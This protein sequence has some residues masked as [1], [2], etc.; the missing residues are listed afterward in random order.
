[1]FRKIVSQL[2]FSPA[3]VG[4][5]SFYAKR[6]RR[7]EVT[8]K[9]GLVFVALAL[10]VQSLVVFQ[11]VESANA[12][13]DSDFVR[14]GI[15]SIDE[16]L[17][18]YDSNSNNIKDIMTYA[19]VTRQE[20]ASTQYT[21]FKVNSTLSWG[22]Q[23]RFSAAQGERTVNITNADGNHVRNV[24]ARPLT[25]WNQSNWNIRAWVGHS[26]KLGWFAIMKV[27]GNLVTNSI[28]NPPAP[29][30]KPTPP[31]PTPTPTPTPEPEPE[32]T[33]E[34]E[35]PVVAGEVKLNKG[36][37]NAS[38]GNVAASSVTARAN[39][40][41]TYTLTAKNIGGTP[42]EATFEDHLGDALE[43]TRLTD[44]GGGTFNEA[45]KKLS[46]PKVTLQPG[47]TQERTFALQVAS[48]IPSTP[49]GQS[50][51]SSYNCA[52]ENTFGDDYINIP[53]E[54]ATPKAIEQAVTQLPQT[55]PAE[56]MM[57]AGVVL[58]VVT[59]FYARSRQLNKEVRLIRKDLNAGTI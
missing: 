28:P 1:M 59:Y 50:D 6:L 24:Y 57:F 49:T 56:N 32:P 46:W 29:K 53:V 15:N 52:I 42:V 18:A 38:Q 26:E 7:E 51:Q 5:L 39:D 37:R 54:C 31:T 27:C 23:P 9:T 36:A 35:L 14:G 3:L 11:P 33:P 44:T 17:R 45:E 21:T 16:F 19:G 58:A 43:Y 55:G 20:I 4:Q 13:S 2:S 40:K 10:V 8:R 25:M 47:E 12:A 22:L 41:L 30:P 34:P 48:A